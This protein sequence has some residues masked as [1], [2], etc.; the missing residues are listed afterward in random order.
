MS[1]LS[2]WLPQ[3]S[4]TLSLCLFKAC[5]YTSSL[6]SLL[7]GETQSERG[8]NPGAES[9][10]PE[11]LIFTSQIK[12]TSSDGPPAHLARSKT[13]KTATANIPAAVANEQIPF[14]YADI[15]VL[16]VADGSGQ[17]YACSLI[18]PLINASEQ[19]PPSAASVMSIKW[20]HVLVTANAVNLAHFRRL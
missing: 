5:C 17:H 3:D 1:V 4:P 6:K 12:S 18:Q 7:R 10:V 9:V 19:Q 2:E 16:M 14:P 20:S 11:I 15:P 8:C 13:A